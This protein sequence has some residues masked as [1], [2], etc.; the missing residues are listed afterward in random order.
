MSIAN[1]FLKNLSFIYDKLAVCKNWLYE[2]Q[3]IDSFKL[4]R[5]VISVGN[6][7]M[8]GTGKTPVVDFLL[9]EC[10]K[11]NLSA[12]V[13]SRNY[14]AEISEM[15][16]VDLGH[17]K[18]A[19]YF[20]DEPFWLQ[21]NNPQAQVVV[22][23]LK[24]QCAIWAE[25]NLTFDLLII[26]DGFQHQDLKRD[27]D[28][29]LIDASIDFHQLNPLPLGRAREGLN[30][31]SRANQIIFTKSKDL[32]NEV[33]KQV[34]NNQNLSE[35]DPKIAQMYYDLV[36]PV[37]K[38]NRVMAFCGV[39]QPTVFY[40]AL[41]EFYGENLKHFVEFPDHHSYN[42]WDIEKILEK[43]NDH[44]VEWIL[45]TEK[46]LVKIKSLKLPLNINIE[47]IISVPLQLQWLQ[48][49]QVIYEFLDQVRR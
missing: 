16:K 49:P 17:P 7:T 33:K 20:G 30:S 24:Y 23:P 31:L 26:D 2:Q 14:K 39:G 3:I 43:A 25:K 37:P 45:T 36:F 11:R 47:K 41:G 15:A 13:V 35:Q 19:Q 32:E 9:K 21:Q 4:N 6:L 46:D 27:L 28:I 18:G 1:S 40:K 12:V 8:G 5:P 29:V 42:S 22:G 44:D 38:E 10:Q 48:Q 34:L